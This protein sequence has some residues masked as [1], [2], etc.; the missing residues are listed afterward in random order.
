MHM[1]GRCTHGTMG[2]VCFVCVIVSSSYG[3]QASMLQLMLW[4]SS[5]PGTGC[6]TPLAAEGGWGCSAAGPNPCQGI[7]IWL[8]CIAQR[9]LFGVV[10]R[11]VLVVQSVLCKHTCLRSCFVRARVRAGLLLGRCCC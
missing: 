1:H 2:C 11:G 10:G 5:T 3:C 4:Y 7:S 6:S 8:S 9:M